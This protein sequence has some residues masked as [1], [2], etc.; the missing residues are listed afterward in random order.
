MNVSRMI[1]D[2]W[3]MLH[4]CVQYESCTDANV[5]PWTYV[6]RRVSGNQA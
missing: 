6:G 2:M 4:A 3:S 1:S 5:S